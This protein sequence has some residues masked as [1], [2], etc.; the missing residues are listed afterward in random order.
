MSQRGESWQE[1][2]KGLDQASNSNHPCLSFVFNQDAK[3]KIQGA[4]ALIAETGYRANERE[5]EETI[6]QKVEKVLR[7][8]EKDRSN[9]EAILPT[10][11]EQH[12][13]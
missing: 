8:R 10:T 2:K 4:S 5:D 6:I 9:W 7:E 11:D 1:E 3:Q 13:P 12:D